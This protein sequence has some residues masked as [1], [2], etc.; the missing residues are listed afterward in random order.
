MKLQIIATGS[1]G[2]CYALHAGGHVLLLDAG[3]RYQELLAALAYDIR[4]VLGCLITHEHQDHLRAAPRLMHAGISCVMSRGTADA[5]QD[6]PQCVQILG[7]KGTAQLGPFTVRA[8]QTQH[9][10]AEPLGFL[11][12][13]RPTGEK[14]VYAT[15]TYYLRYRFPGVHYWLVE[16]NY[17]QELMDQHQHRG[18]MADSLRHRLLRSHM[19]LE[20][21]LQVFEANDLREARKIVLLH[22][23]DDRAHETRMVAE[24]FRNTAVSTIAATAGA[25]VDLELTPF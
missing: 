13:Y 24:V 8:F 14:L 21:L 3:I 16:C 15:D 12:S 4:G 17:I 5:L 11:I 23:S 7:D 9:D 2:N 6:G 18:E 25:C 22:M 1:A 19:S 10:A 20:R